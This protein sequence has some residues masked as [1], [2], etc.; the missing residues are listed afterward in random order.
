MDCLINLVILLA[1]LEFFLVYCERKILKMFE[2]IF[3]EI[4]EKNIKESFSIKFKKLTY[5]FF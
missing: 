1:F 3:H 2:N 5:L 4:P